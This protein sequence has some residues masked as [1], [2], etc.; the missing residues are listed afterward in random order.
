[1]HVFI[2]YFICIYMEH[3]RQNVNSG[4]MSI[5]DGARPADNN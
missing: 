3:E 4:E 5:F 1:M 2:L